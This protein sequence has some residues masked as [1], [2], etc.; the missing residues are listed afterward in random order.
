MG[1]QILVCPECSSGRV[2]LV[3]PGGVNARASAGKYLCRE[4]SSQFDSG[5]YR[6]K[7]VQGG[8]LTGLARQLDRCDSV[9]EIDLSDRID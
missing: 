9:A 3:A 1:E 4:C 5:T 6:E 2:E 8:S 7:T